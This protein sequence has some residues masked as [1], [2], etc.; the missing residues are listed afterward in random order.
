MQ[1]L[2]VPPIA[3]APGRAGR[4]GPTLGASSHG[5]YPASAADFGHPGPV[6]PHP[7]AACPAPPAFHLDGVS[8][9]RVLHAT[10]SYLGRLNSS[11][12]QQQ[13]ASSKLT[14]SSSALP[15]SGKLAKGCNMH[16]L[17]TLLLILF[18]PGS[19]INYTAISVF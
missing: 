16:I 15:S 17:S 10:G 9:A 5:P 12:E 8:P 2:T 14:C 19:Y 6:Q 3:S 7:T 11:G 4:C 1:K 18:I 13:A